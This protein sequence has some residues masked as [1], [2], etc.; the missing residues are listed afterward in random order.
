MITQ[1]EI[2]KSSEVEALTKVLNET[3][4][5]GV[6][7]YS[8][9]IIIHHLIRRGYLSKERTQL[10]KELHDNTEFSYHDI[11]EMVNQYNRMEKELPSYS[12]ELN[13]KLDKV[14]AIHKS[15]VP[16]VHID[17]RLVGIVKEGKRYSIYDASS[18]HLIRLGVIDE[19]YHITWSSHWVITPSILKWGIDKLKDIRKENGI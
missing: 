2:F 10:I 11:I 5:R 15:V 8:D 12:V 17:K 14:N 16:F 6:L 18:N 13:D 19:N 4:I 7:K 1:G 9:S 3:G